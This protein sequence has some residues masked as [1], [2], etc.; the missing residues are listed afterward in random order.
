M[1]LSSARRHAAL[2]RVFLCLFA[3]AALSLLAAAPALAFGIAGIAADIA[4]I[5]NVPGSPEGRPSFRFFGSEQGM[6]QNTPQCF[7]LDARGF[8]C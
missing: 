6:L 2:G 8:L 3:G 7:A 4:D 1:T 5:A